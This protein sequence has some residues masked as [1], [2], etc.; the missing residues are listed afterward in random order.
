MT[1]ARPPA[2]SISLM[3]FVEGESLRQRLEREGPLD[4]AVAVQLVGEIADAL[5]YAHHQGVIHRDIQAGEYPAADGSRRGERL[6]HCPRHRCRHLGG[7]AR[8]Q[9]EPARAWPSVR[10]ST[11]SPEQVT[12]GA[13]DGRTDIYCPGLRAVRNARRSAPFRGPLTDCRAGPTTPPPPFPRSSAAGTMSPL[14]LEQALVKALANLP[15]SD[16]PAPREFRA[17]LAGETTGALAPC[18]GPHGAEASSL[19]AWWPS[20]RS[21]CWLATADDTPRGTRRAAI[22]CRA[23]SQE[24]WRRLDQRAVQRWGLRGDHHGARQ[25]AG[26]SGRGPV[27]GVR[28]SRTRRSA[29]RRSDGNSGSAMSWMAASGWAASGGGSASS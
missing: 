8:G 2:S 16:S 20:P 24:Y 14:Q 19:P 25:G 9:A 18:P 11:W 28:V 15:T 29:P 1:P 13:I 23:G 26:P 22:D 17:A 21:C 27:T 3:P 5:D 7:A 4:S 6:R 12:G 10:R